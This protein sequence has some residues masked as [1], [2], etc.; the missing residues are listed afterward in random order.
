MLRYLAKISPFYS[1]PGPPTVT[2]YPQLQQMLENLQYVRHGVAA[3]NKAENSFAFEVL[4][5][6]TQKEPYQGA[7]P[8]RKEGG[9]V[10][11]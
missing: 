9:V 5:Q 3:V 6:G 4:L 2:I 10:G 7:V 1:P 8:S 11:G